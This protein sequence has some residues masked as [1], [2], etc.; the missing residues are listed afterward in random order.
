MDAMKTPLGGTSSAN[1]GLLEFGASW[2]SA[3][4]MVKFTKWAWTIGQPERL[5]HPRSACSSTAPAGRFRPTIPICGVGLIGLLAAAPFAGGAEEADA[6]LPPGAQIVWELSKAYRETTPTRE[7]ICLNGLWRWQPAMPTADPVPTNRWGFFKVPGSWPGITDYMQKDSQ[8][9]HVHP[10]WKETRLR[11]VTA[12]WHQREFTVPSE[13]TGRRI[14]LSAEYLNSFAAVYVDGRK[15]GELHFP[16]GEVDLTDICQPGARHVLSLLVVAL[17]LKGVMLSYTDSA[18]AREVRGSVARRGLCGDVF[19]VST[20]RA[21]RLADVR[22]TTSVRQGEITLDTAL[23]DLPA[24]QSWTLAARVTDRGG[25]VKEFQSEPFK[26]EQMKAGRFAFTE[27]WLPDKRWD[28]H[29]PQH[30]FDLHLSLRNAA[31]AV[32]D[33]LPPVRRAIGSGF[34]TKTITLSCGKLTTG[35]TVPQWSSILMLRNLKSPETYFQAAF[36]IQSPWSIKNPPG[37]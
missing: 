3:L 16:A 2:N 30:Q 15:A 21:A 5:R 24:G 14:A 17:P 37:R 26:S 25:V 36:R 31:G 28:L 4:R 34:E 19:L 6:P 29:T 8:T 27:K 35:V 23:Q 20:P 11:E 32:A 22:V 1:P 12:A 7:R 18:S 33:A 9:V 10:A 13:W